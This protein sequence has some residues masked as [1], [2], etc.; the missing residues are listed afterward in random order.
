M[1]FEGV[2]T[3]LNIKSTGV[4]EE[5]PSDSYVP[6]E[7]ED[8]ADFPY[9]IYPNKLDLHFE[10]SVERSAMVAIHNYNQKCLEF[11]WQR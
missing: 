1:G 2:K 4:R 5:P 6:L 10:Q 9:V 3:K 11:H 8:C 7:D